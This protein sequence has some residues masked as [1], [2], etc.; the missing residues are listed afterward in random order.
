[1]LLLKVLCLSVTHIL[2]F[3]VRERIPGPLTQRLIS[4]LLEENINITPLQDS[5]NKLKGMI[6]F[7]TFLL[8]EFINICL[9]NVHYLIGC[10]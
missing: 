7:G 2:F 6:N 5:G 8:T 4:A 9:N 1:M 10:N 3:S